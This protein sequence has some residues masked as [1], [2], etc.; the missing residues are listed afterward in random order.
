[1]GFCVGEPWNARAIN[2]R[3]GFTAATSQS[4]WADHPEKIL[5]TRRDWV[6]KNPHT[7]RAL[8]S[9]VMEA[10]RWIEASAENKRETAQILSR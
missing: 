4:I 8:V 10:A 6:A 9:A 7:A 1:V 3:I 5:G 2:D